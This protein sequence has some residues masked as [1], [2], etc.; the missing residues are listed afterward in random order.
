MAK[1]P[2]SGRKELKNQ[3]SPS[4]NNPFQRI[5]FDASD[6]QQ[7]SISGGGTKPLC[8][9]TT[10][11]RA[12]LDGMVADLSANLTADL[13][14]FPTAHS[15]L[16]FKLK[17]KA[18]AKSH[19]PL[20]LASKCELPLAGHGRLNEMLVAAKLPDLSILRRVILEDKTKIIEAN[21][22]VISSIEVWTKEKKSSLNLNHFSELG[23]IVLKPFWYSQDEINATNIYQL[24]ALLGRL[25]LQ[26][27]IIE[28]DGHVP[29]FELRE[30]EAITTEQWDTLLSYPG[31]RELRPA[32]LASANASSSVTSAT[33][34]QHFAIGQPAINLPTVAV[35][36]TGVSSSNPQLNGWIAG[37][38]TYVSKPDTDHVHGT[39]VAS[40]VAAGHLLNIGF[41]EVPCKILDVAALETSGSYV[42]DLIVRLEDAVKR[43]S[44]INVWNISIGAEMRHDQQFSDF[45]QAIDRLSIK[46][47]ILFVVAAGNYVHEPR[48]SWPITAHL[49]SDFITAPADAPTAL[50]VGALVQMGDNSTL[51][52][53]GEPAP[54]SR[55]GP[56]PV[57]TSKPD[58]VHYGGNI[59]K[60]FEEG[61]CSTLMLT[62]NGNAHRKS[63]TSFA[64]PVIAALCAHTWQSLQSKTGINVSPSLVKAALI[65]AAQLSNTDYEPSM[66][67]YYGAGLPQ[68]VLSILYDRSDSFTLMFEVEL[69]PG[70]TRWRKT[71]YPIPAALRQG[72]KL[73]AEVIVTAAYQPV[74]NANFGAEY[75]R[76]NLDLSFG[77]LKD[78]RIQGKVPQE[79]EPGE[80]TYEKQLVEHG[81]KWST[82]K[83]HR[84]SFPGGVSGD[85]WALQAKLQL[86]AAEPPLNQP[87]K[88][89]IF[90]TLRSLDSNTDVYNDGIRALN[91]TQWTRTQLPNRLPI[92]VY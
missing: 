73:Q 71:P 57:H 13:Q 36:D 39:G 41:P 75:I 2:I 86:R 25:N 63:G 26:A 35:F 59:H 12:K 51:A 20:T 62:P 70:L 30:I 58:L 19:R 83:V 7:F 15:T 4:T 40:L 60:P 17:D 72:N 3:L 32:Y 54:Y 69:V 44:G 90:V 33:N 42:T 67:Y 31:L 92:N 47:N 23:R 91:A 50:S 77:T 48:R 5:V 29:I 27:Q 6:L 52:Q 88:V 85:D 82:V 1:R 28:T 87:V 9:V 89:S 38:T 18:L 79:L 80:N 64:A 24:E 65:H 56:G 14:N 43:N 61:V 34:S 10:Q 8:E 55:R 53:A 74:V 37:R 21:L 81:G 68:D 78:G 22:S 11:Y 66:R 76:T 46:H 84:A 49:T 16:I 45:A